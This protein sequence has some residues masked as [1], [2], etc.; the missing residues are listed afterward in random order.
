[1]TAHSWRGPVGCTALLGLCAAAY[2]SGLQR[3]ALYV[4]APFVDSHSAQ[5]FWVAFSTIL[6]VCVF[7]LG[8]LRRLKN[9]AFANTLV[10]IAGGVAIFSGA[11]TTTWVLSAGESGGSPLTPAG[12]AAGVQAGVLVAG[13]IA[14][15]VGFWFNDQ[16]RRREDETLRNDGS[17]LDQDKKRVE[18]ERF[19]RTVELIGHENAG[20][21]IGA[22]HSLSGLA[23][24]N[25]ARRSTVVEVICAYLRQPFDY[26]TATNPE[27][28]PGEARARRPT[29]D[30]TELA[31]REY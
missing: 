30:A 13:V 5:I 4:V 18:E 16:R 8:L 24:D 9:L 17:R 23:R 1:M 11:L 12:V 20:V 27:P 25:A 10:L 19:I 3:K 7:P 29:S 22:L 26:R 14:A 28:V 15:A 6:I 2:N 31:R 21:R